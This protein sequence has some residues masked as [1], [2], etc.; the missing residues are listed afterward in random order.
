MPREIVMFPEAAIA[1][2]EEIM[3]HHPDLLRILSKYPGRQLE[4]KVATIAAYCGLAV[5]GNFRESE[6][7]ALFELLLRKLKEKSMPVISRQQ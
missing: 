5:D 4:V 2:N 7:E 1:M 3:N 6:L